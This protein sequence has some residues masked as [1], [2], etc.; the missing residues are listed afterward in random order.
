M[1]TPASSSALPRIA[2]REPESDLHHLLREAQYVLL[3]HPVAAQAAFA[4]LVA[5]GRRFGRSEEGR[6]WRRRL[7]GSD[8][9]RRGRVVWE[10]FSLK[11]LEENPPGV[12]P[13]AYLEAMVKA[14]SMADLEPM[15]ARLFE[16]GVDDAD[17]DPA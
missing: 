12:L 13:T 11:M 3:R 5:E 8:L 15:L 14:A 1:P 10:V 9:M 17:S 4:A 6:A 2:I 16:L 7:E